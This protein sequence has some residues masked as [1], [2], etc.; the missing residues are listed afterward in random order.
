MSQVRSLVVAIVATVAVV[1]VGGCS[2]LQETMIPEIRYLESMRGY[3]VQE[4]EGDRTLL[5]DPATGEKMRC[6]DDVQHWLPEIQR[7]L[8]DDHGKSQVFAVNVAVASPVLL[9]AAVAALPSAALACGSLCPA[10]VLN[11][12]DAVGADDGRRLYDEGDAAGAVSLLESYAYEKPAE[13]RAG[14]TYFWLGRAHLQL[15]EPE[16]AARAFS[17]FV[18]HAQVQ[19]PTLYDEAEKAAGALPRCD[20]SPVPLFGPPRPQ[21]KK[22]PPGEPAPTPLPESAPLSTSTTTDL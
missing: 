3:A 21:K 7:D 13:A 20:Q 4:K 10:T 16:K 14:E 19:K 18:R 22:A 17:T 2:T 15:N 6:A 1:A 8:E 11:W 12:G 5:I 9:V